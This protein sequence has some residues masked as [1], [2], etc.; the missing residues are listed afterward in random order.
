MHVH[1]PYFVDPFE[2]CIMAFV[3]DM[4]GVFDGVGDFIARDIRD[5]RAK[6]SCSKHGRDIKRKNSIQPMGSLLRP[7]SLRNRVWSACILYINACGLYAPCVRVYSIFLRRST[8]RTCRLS[9][10]TKTNKFKEFACLV[11]SHFLLL[12]SGLF[13]RFSLSGCLP[14]PLH[15]NFGMQ[16]HPWHVL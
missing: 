5:L 8:G 3:G 4:H 9:S 14:A 15:T 13:L 10:L 12:P 16:G 1:M 7:I 11:Q 6:G 2:S